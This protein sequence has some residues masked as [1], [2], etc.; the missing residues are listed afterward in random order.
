LNFIT[1]VPDTAPCVRQSSA[2]ADAAESKK[3][4]TLWPVLVGAQGI[5]PWTSPV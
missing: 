1:N 5:E 2:L 4:L 3:H